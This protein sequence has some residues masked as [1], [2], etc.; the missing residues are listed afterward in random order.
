MLVKKFKIKIGD[1]KKIIIHVPD[2]PA[3][4][5]ELI[6][7]KED[8]CYM[9]SNEIL[10]QIPRHRA[11]KVLNALRREDIYTNAR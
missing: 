5:A 7:L 2:I 3:G 9:T 6:I 4:E 11:G 1:D 10:S 8:E